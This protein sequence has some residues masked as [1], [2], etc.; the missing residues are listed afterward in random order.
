MSSTIGLLS[1]LRPLIV[2]TEAPSTEGKGDLGPYSIF[3]VAAS[4][5]LL[6][7]TMEVVGVVA[8]AIVSE[9]HAH[10][11]RFSV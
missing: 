6:H 8:A 1:P 5:L 7:E 4:L 10:Q 11:K 2:K 3:V 9:P